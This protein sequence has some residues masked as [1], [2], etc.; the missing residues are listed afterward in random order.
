MGAD[1]NQDM[2]ATDSGANTRRITYVCV[3]CVCVCACVRACVGAC[4]RA[5]V[6]ACVCVV[7]YL[8]VLLDMYLISLYDGPFKF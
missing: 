6:R 5:C 4:V 7:Q 2:D 3:W 1:E 8:S